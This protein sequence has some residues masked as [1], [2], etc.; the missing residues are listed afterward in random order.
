MVA[1]LEG[2]NKRRDGSTFPVHVRFCKL[3]NVYAVANAR[4]ITLQKQA[5][6]ELESRVEAQSQVA[7]ESGLRMATRLISSNVASTKM[8]ASVSLLSNRELE[9]FTLIGRG[10]SP[11]E[12]A[13]ELCISVRTVNSHRE[14]I[15]K[16]LNLKNVRALVLYAGEW[17]KDQGM[18]L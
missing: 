15:K 14:H 18:Q 16:K 1:E 13:E 9:V 6:E 12:I 5:E 10:D 17:V 3:D 7:R 4:D 11:R 8:V 2:T